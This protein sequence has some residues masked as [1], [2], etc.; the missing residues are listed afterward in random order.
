MIYFFEVTYRDLREAVSLSV[1]TGSKWCAAMDPDKTELCFGDGGLPIEK[2]MKPIVVQTPEE[3]VTVRWEDLPE[4]VRQTYRNGQRMYD[5]HRVLHLKYPSQRGSGRSRVSIEVTVG[6]GQDR[7]AMGEVE[8]RL[9]LPGA[10]LGVVR[11]T[12]DDLPEDG[13]I[14]RYWEHEAEVFDRLLDNVL[15]GLLVYIGSDGSVY[16]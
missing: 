8:G 13:E 12:C 10:I 5:L 15:V 9:E 4:P 7:R 2:D 3:I 16:G 6:P 14:V 1:L 11:D